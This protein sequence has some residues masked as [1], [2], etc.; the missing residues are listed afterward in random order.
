[1][2]FKSVLIFTIGVHFLGVSTPRQKK[3]YNLRMRKKGAGF[4]RSL[5]VVKHLVFAL[6]RKII[7]STRISHVTGYP[8][9]VSEKGG[10]KYR[11]KLKA[12]FSNDIIVKCVTILIFP[13]KYQ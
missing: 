5:R 4:V 10:H 8:A 12:T 13:L 9:V 7:K 11:L 1:M 6:A 3:L 2:A